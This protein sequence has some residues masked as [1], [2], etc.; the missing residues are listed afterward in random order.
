MFTNA[1]KH[2]YFTPISWRPLRN[3]LT[4]W[5]AT[6]SRMLWT[7]WTPFILAGLSFTPWLLSIVCELLTLL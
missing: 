6:L 2:F 5:G 3:L 1:I 7:L 4:D